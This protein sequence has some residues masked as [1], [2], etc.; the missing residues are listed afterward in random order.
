MTVVKELKIN[1]QTS[2]QEVDISKFLKLRV[3]K[4]QKKEIYENRLKTEMMLKLYGE[5]TTEIHIKQ[6]LKV[7]R[8][9]TSTTKLL[10]FLMGSTEHLRF[11]IDIAVHHKN[12]L[13]NIK[14]IPFLDMENRI[15]YLFK[16]K[17]TLV[18]D[19]IYSDREKKKFISLVKSVYPDF[20]IREIKQKA[21]SYE[22]NSI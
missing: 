7:R 19:Y 18:G 21:K 22:I 20:V 14:H 13:I 17:L 4:E 16:D 3:H 8:L 11:N 6:S 9:L 1:N 15:V 10:S 12:S 5:A 2:T